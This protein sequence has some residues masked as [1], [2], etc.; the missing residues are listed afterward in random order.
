MA[1]VTY[2]GMTQADAEKYLTPRP[3][4]AASI[5]VRAGPGTSQRELV[6][7]LTPVLPKGVEAIT[8][9]ASAQ[10]NTD[11][12]SG[13]FLTLFT[14]FLLVFSG[15]ALLVATFSIHNTFAIVVAQ[16]TRENAL[17]RALGA[18]RRQV[19]RHDA[20][21]GER[22]RRCSPRSPVSPAASASRPGSRRCSPRSASR[23][24]TALS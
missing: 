16:R 15:I 12:I 7:E 10:E 4:E 21:R 19:T 8:G 11:M 13:Q 3:G 23:S 9:E 2:T 24:P 5:Q 14:T 22:R 17:L 1:Q 6:D 20:R 18:S